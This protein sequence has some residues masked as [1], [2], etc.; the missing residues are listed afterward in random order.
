MAWAAS[1]RRTTGPVP[2]QTR[3]GNA[4]I[5][6]RRCSTPQSDRA[7]G[8]RLVPVTHP[9]EESL[10]ATLEIVNQGG[11]GP[12]GHEPVDARGP[13]QK[14]AAVRLLSQHAVGRRRWSPFAAR[15]D[16]AVGEDGD[17]FTYAGGKWIAAE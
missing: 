13:E 3:D 15:T 5:S 12:L 9:I 10:L 11:V 16:V 2:A 7:S 8:Q 1:P 4:R 14:G 17:V 6:L